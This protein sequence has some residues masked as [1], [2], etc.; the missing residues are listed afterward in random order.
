M[1]INDI[2]SLCR[3]SRLNYKIVDNKNTIHIL[4]PTYLA[5]QIDVYGIAISGPTHCP[6]CGE[7]NYQLEEQDCTTDLQV[8]CRKC[9]N[10]FGTL[11]VIK[12][13]FQN[14]ICCPNCGR[15]DC[16]EDGDGYYKCNACNYIW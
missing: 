6:N 7:I 5:M 15:T 8:L 13:D 10:T 12:D 4:F 14:L 11:G 3:R 9:K 2:A 16:Q 1:S